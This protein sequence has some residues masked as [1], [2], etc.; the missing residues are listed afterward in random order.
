MAT[1]ETSFRLWAIRQQPSGL[2]SRNR[3]AFRAAA[4][5]RSKVLGVGIGL[6][7]VIDSNRGMC[8]FSHLLQWQDADLAQP[9][10]RRLGCR[11]GSTTT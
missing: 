5:P 10:R 9:L 3:K 11:Y 1:E 8:N 2:S 6:S 4:V 7:G